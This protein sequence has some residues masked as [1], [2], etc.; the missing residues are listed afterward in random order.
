MI[1]PETKYLSTEDLMYMRRCIEISALARSPEFPF[2]A[3]L[4][5]EGRVISE[6]YNDALNSHQVY[7]HAEMLVL[8][9]AQ[10][11]LTKEELAR[12]TLY[13]TVEPCP[14]CAFAIQELAI[15][16]VVFGL[17]SPV[18]GGF[19][20]WSILQDTL[21]NQTFPNSFKQT[22]E[23]LPGVLKSEVIKVWQKWDLE[24]WGKMMDKGVFS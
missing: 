9:D 24:K 13:S 2:G 11:Q 12:C 20:R 7:R 4:E 5:F 1:I 19:S 14:M 3:L 15:R 23:I 17:R 6:R 8:L 21:L 16:R 22:P 18:M 10:E